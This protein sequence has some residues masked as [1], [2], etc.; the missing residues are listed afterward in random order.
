LTAYLG[1]VQS[2]P[3][4]ISD[5]GAAVVA[6]AVEV[7]VVVEGV[8]EEAVALVAEL[9]FMPLELPLVDAE[10]LAVVAPDFAAALPAASVVSPMDWARAQGRADNDSEV[11]SI[12]SAV[13]FAQKPLL[14]LFDM[15]FL[16]LGFSSSTI[17]S[18]R[19]IF[20]YWTSWFGF[21]LYGIIFQPL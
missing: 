12:A 14:S 21:P 13:S 16:D 20:Q 15:S 3:G 18:A 19:S 1:S 5:A 6:G 8:V 11:A 10:V 2:T 9:A 4:G 17:C 7:E